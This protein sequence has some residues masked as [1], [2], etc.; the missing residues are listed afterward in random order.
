[1]PHRTHRG[2]ERCHP[3]IVPVE[4]PQ[5][6]GFQTFPAW[7]CGGLTWRL[8]DGTELDDTRPFARNGE[9]ALAGKR[10]APAAATIL[11]GPTARLAAIA[12]SRTGNPLRL[13]ARENSDCP[14]RRERPSVA[15]NDGLFPDLENVALATRA[16]WIHEP[17]GLRYRVALCASP[18]R[19]QA[20]RR[21]FLPPARP[22]G[23]QAL[24]EVDA[25]LL[26]SRT[27]KPFSSPDAASP[28]ILATGN[29]QLAKGPRPCGRA[30]PIRT[31]FQR[32][33]VA[34]GR[35]AR[36]QAVPRSRRSAR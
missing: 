4:P 29:W 24:T 36:S 28:Y 3:F 30:R 1:M 19:V 13:C 26:S 2:R 10:P 20:R 18:R 12:T 21:S 5:N 7:V 14:S 35:P 6:R 25:P 32:S 33:G 34:R 11:T 27:K 31:H 8:L 16:H 9:I 22:G 17:I 23:L 15:R